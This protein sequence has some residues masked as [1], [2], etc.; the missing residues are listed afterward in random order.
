ML[1]YSKEQIQRA[2]E[3]IEQ[4]R[5]TT[6]YLHVPPLLLAPVRG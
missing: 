4:Q 1:G 3:D 2:Y 6:T 5:R